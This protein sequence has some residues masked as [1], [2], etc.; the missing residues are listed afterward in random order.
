MH[1]SFT[2]IVNIPKIQLANSGETFVIN[3]KIIRRL[4]KIGRDKSVVLDGVPAEILKLGGDAMTP[5]L[6][7]LLEISLNNAT[8][9]SDW[10]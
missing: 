2:A 6:A 10:K 9:P 5:F 3:T 7:R 1:P 4:A 8:N